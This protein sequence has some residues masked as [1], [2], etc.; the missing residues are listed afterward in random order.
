MQKITD[1]LILFGVDAKEAKDAIQ[2]TA[3]PLQKGNYVKNSY[4]DMVIE[5]EK[6]YPT[7]LML[8]STAVAMPHTT[9]AHVNTSAVCIAKLIHPVIFH[10]MD[11]PDSTVEAEILFMM[12]IK[13]PNAQLE[14]LQK[15]MGVFTNDKAVYALTAATNRASFIAAVKTYLK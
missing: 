5:R 1:D 8:K 2:Q 4:V 13:D 7:G 3:V 12:A 15:V 6:K 10:K 14:T 11:D 9:G